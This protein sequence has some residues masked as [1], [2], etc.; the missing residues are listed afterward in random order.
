MSDPGELNISVSVG[1]PY[2]ALLR[3]CKRQLVLQALSACGGDVSKTAR[4]LGIARQNLYR[5]MKELNV[6][7]A[8]QGESSRVDDALK[9]IRVGGQR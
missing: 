6:S 5:L 2:A 4:L 8:R 1:Q 7:P 9:A 3:E